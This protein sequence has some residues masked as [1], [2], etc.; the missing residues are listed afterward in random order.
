MNDLSPE[1]NHGEQAQEKSTIESGNLT[2]HHKR[3]RLYFESGQTA[4]RTLK[5]FI[6]FLKTSQFDS[7]KEFYEIEIPV[8]TSPIT[9]DD[10]RKLTEFPFEF[11]LLQ[12]GNNIVASTGTKEQPYAGEQDSQERANTRL[13]FHSHPSINPAVN[14]PSFSDLALTADEKKQLILAYPGGLM[15]FRRPIYNPITQMFSLDDVREI[16]FHFCESSGIEVSD[17]PHQGLRSFFDLTDEEQVRFQREFT[18]TTRMILREASWDDKD[19][20][21]EIMDA[22]NLR[23]RIDADY[24]VIPSCL[25]NLDLKVLSEGQRKNISTLGHLIDDIWNRYGIFGTT[26][27]QTN[28]YLEFLKDTL[29]EDLSKKGGIKAYRHSLEHLLAEVNKLKDKN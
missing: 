17:R 25:D 29:T 3:Q 12:R 21:T 5:D 11:Q 2:N 7:E 1:I 26:H 22:I 16:L 19:G 10:V 27:A 4:P 9:S 20:V 24:P 14:T 18:E 13:Y 15:A 6:N 28:S 23:K 8:A